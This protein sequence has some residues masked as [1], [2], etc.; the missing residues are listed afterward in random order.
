VDSAVRRCHY[1][2]SMGG[3]TVVHYQS[4]RRLPPHFSQLELSFTDRSTVSCLTPPLYT[5]TPLNQLTEENAI[6][7][8]GVSNI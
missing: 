4:I 1:T 5:I 6:A 3:P 2:A 7:S 8:Y